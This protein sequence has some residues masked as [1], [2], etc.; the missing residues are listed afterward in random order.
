M[1][2]ESVVRHMTTFKGVDHWRDLWFVVY[3]FRRLVIDWTKEAIGRN[4]AEVL[5]NIN[6]ILTLFVYLISCLKS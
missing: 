2:R 5:I 1:N 3:G 4:F 6:V